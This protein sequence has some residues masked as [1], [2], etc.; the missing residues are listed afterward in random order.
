[1]E[2]LIDDLL[3]FSRAGRSQTVFDSV[4][5]NAVWSMAE[6]DCRVGIEAT[7]A[8][9]DADQLPVLRG[10]QTQLRQL[11]QNLLSNALKFARP[12]VVPIVEVTAER[13]GDQ[14]VI[15]IGDNGVGVPPEDRERIFGMFT[16][17]DETAGEPGS[18]IGLAICQRVAVAHG[19]QIWVE[20]TDSGGSRFCVALPAA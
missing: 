5:L 1:M 14:W 2:Q 17:L 4:D 11:L 3:G 8:R 20:E 18:G 12:G 7:G 6:S 9:I 16:R 10:D 19:G 13:A 15:A